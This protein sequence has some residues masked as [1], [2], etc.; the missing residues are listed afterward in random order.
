MGIQWSYQREVGRF[1]IEDS[2]INKA[3]GGVWCWVMG[4]ILKNK[5]KKSVKTKT[6]GDKGFCKVTGSGGGMLG[7]IEKL[8][9][10]LSNQSNNNQTAIKQ[11]KQ[12]DLSHSFRGEDLVNG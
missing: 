12:Y 7:K 11:Q 1:E 9:D 2:D 4:M 6:V 3:R 10:E 8:K 5:K